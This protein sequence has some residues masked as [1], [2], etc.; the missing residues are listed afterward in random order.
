VFFCRT[1]AERNGWRG[2]F[3]ELDADGGEGGLLQAIDHVELSQPFDYFDEAALFYHSV[4]GLRPHQSEDIAAPDGLLRSR[5]VSDA[6]GRLRLALTI[7]RLGGG[8]SSRLAEIQHVAFAT[9]DALAAA[10]HVRDRGVPLL[11]VPDNYYEDLAARADL[12]AD[13]LEALRDL[14]VLNDAEPSGELLHFFTETIGDRLFFEVIER[15]GAYGGYGAAN[16][17]VRLAAHLQRA[18]DGD[19]DRLAAR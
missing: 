15:R 10:R 13:M 2:D 5:S 6:T 12:S 17:A 8:A 16:S 4:L 18:G 14:G 11:A 7:P 1:E 9:V 19:N 3:L